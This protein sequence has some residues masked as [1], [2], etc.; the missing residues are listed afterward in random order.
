MILDTLSATSLEWSRRNRSPAAAEGAGRGRVRGR[1]SHAN[2]LF[3]WEE[4]ASQ[5]R[6]GGQASQVSRLRTGDP[7]AG[8]W[9]PGERQ[10]GARAA[11]EAHLRG[12]GRRQPAAT[13]AP[14][15]G[16]GGRRGQPAAPPALPG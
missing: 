6:P 10:G 11:S 4:A 16:G 14:P 2:H 5:R 12:G 9:C 13:V 1:S 15:P 3:L 8:G 7:G